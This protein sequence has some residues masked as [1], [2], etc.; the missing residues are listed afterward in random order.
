MTS[1]LANRQY[2]LSDYKNHEQLHISNEL[3]IDIIER[4]N[5][6]AKRVG[7]PSYQKT[8][9]FKRNHYHN[10]NIKKENITSADWETIR[11]FKKTTLA[12]NTEGIEVYMDKIRS[13]LNK[14]T[15]KTYDLML[16]EI[17]YI[18]KDIN[19]KENKESF[20]NIGEAIFEIGSFN[21]F[22]SLL[23]ATLYKDLIKVYPFMKD[24][25]IK[26]FQS[27]KGLFETINYCD[28]NE[29][30]DTFCKYNKEN[31]KRRALSS[32]F[33]ICADLDIISKAEMTKIIV[34]FI[35]RVKKDIEKEGKLNNVEEMVQNISIM[36]NAGKKFLTNLDEFD[37][38]LQEIEMFSTMNHK[39]YPSLS[40]KIVF[41]FMDLY[42]E[43]EELEE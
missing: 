22:W 5:R 40:S 36:I 6:I 23:Y 29:N 37:Y 30:Y 18:M 19:N 27:F 20:E 12:K 21:K 8:P 31:E 39:K 38:I 24:I 34:G 42:E 43:L 28:S 7:A 9:V 3:N 4:I 41:K 1:I 32:F 11:N 17:K 15:D 16:D 33:V 13:C 2:T 26:N 35:D 14:L 10:K 25:C